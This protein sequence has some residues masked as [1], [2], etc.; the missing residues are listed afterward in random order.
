MSLE[1]YEDAIEYYQKA[2]KCE[3][4]NGNRY[5]NLG[6]AQAT[7]NKIAD[8]MV[9]FAK[10]DEFGVNED[11][12][13][14]MYH[15]LGI[16]NQQLGRLDDA[17][18]NLKKSEILIPADMDIMK[19]K[20]TIYGIKDDVVNGLNVANQMKLIAPSDYS[21]YQVAYILL[22]QANRYEEAFKELIYARKN[23]MDFPY[24]LCSD[25]VS[26]E[27]AMYEKDGDKNHFLKG[28]E[29]LKYYLKKEK[30]S[31]EEVIEIYLEAAE[32]YLQLETA[33]EVLSCLKATKEPV[34]SYNNGILYYE[35]EYI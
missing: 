11:V 32:L 2:V 3:P 31:Q 30:A 28:L 18:I 22:R 27:L 8:T 10:A 7:I 20:A 23:L 25:M 29:Y 26:F 13:A 14:Q 34:F 12:A 5:F 19:R 16:M 21:G 15:I 6:Y 17:L 9:S 24:E 35:K 1:R 4:N 33:D